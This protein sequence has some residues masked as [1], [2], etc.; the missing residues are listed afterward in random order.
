MPDTITI[1]FAGDLCLQG[2]R[3][4]NY[5]VAGPIRKLLQGSDL[6]I[7]N[8]EM[9]LTRAV[10]ATPNQPCN[11]KCEPRMNPVLE[12]FHGFS[13]AN[14]H[15]MDYGLAGLKE[16]CAFLDKN[17]KFRY[18]AGSCLE[19]SLQPLRL[20]LNGIKVAL[21]GATRWYNAGPHRAGTAPMRIHTLSKIIKKLK[22]EC[23]FVIITPHWNYENVD[24]PAPAERKRGHQLIDAG[25]D[26]VVG[27]HPHQIQGYEIY[28]GKYIFHSLGNFIF[29][30]FDLS[31][32]AWAQTFILSVKVNRKHQY[33]IDQLPVQSTPTRIQALSGT[34]RDDF[35]RRLGRLNEGLNNRRRYRRLFYQDAEKI[36]AKTT[37]ALQ[38]SQSGPQKTGSGYGALL[39]RLHRIQLQDILIKLYALKNSIRRDFRNRLKRNPGPRES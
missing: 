21:I 28:H 11:L 4:A 17:Q 20:E 25:A 18:G 26:L 30:L 34:A 14:N 12:L 31:R 5:A 3:A 6:N 29:P 27:S 32:K 36:I 16:T 22:Q 9:P 10:A 8:L 35:N 23:Y 38:R 2:C 37:G 33:S 24:Y 19:Q 7:V 1:N 15:I 39:K 13:L